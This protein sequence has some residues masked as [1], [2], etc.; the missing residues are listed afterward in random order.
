MTQYQPF[1]RLLFRPPRRIRPG[2]LAMALSAVALGSAAPAALA[3]DGVWNAGD[4]TWLQN[5]SNWLN[6]VVPNG[7]TH[8]ATFSSSG[9][10]TV[11][12]NGGVTIENIT[13]DGVASAYNIVPS[14]NF[15]LT[16]STDNS[17]IE[18]TGTGAN[19]Q[20]ISANLVRRGATVISNDYESPEHTLT[21]TGKLQDWTNRDSPVTLSGS[22]TGANTISGVIDDGTAGGKTTLTKTGSGTWIL[23]G[24]NTYTGPTAIN[25]GMLFISGTHHPSSPNGNAYTI[26]GGALGGAGGK[27]TAAGVTLKGAEGSALNV[28]G[29][30]LG[31]VGPQNALSAPGMLEFDLGSTLLDI[32]LAGEGALKFVLNTPESSDRVWLSS[33]TLEIGEGQLSLSNFSFD[34]SNWSAEGAEGTY[35]LFSTSSVNGINGSLAA[36]GLSVNFGGYALTLSLGTDDLDFQTLQLDV[37]AV[38]EPSVISAI[39]LGGLVLIG[40]RQRWRRSVV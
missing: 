15:A 38:P 32:S 11:T 17:L 30:G 25:G 39:L 7:D 21:I 14:G 24:D 1:Y 8:S 26:E 23:S 18:A 27:I 5:S 20:V 3:V 4:G 6:S 40:L 13:F 2:L 35:V 22:N 37:A 31:T 36:D 9:G 29:A 19:A 33:G 34:L 10:G 16:L 12:I 28:S